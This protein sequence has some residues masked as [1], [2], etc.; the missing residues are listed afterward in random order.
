MNIQE[1]VQHAKETEPRLAKLNSARGDILLREVFKQIVSEIRQKSQ[2]I[3]KVPGLGQFITKKALRMK[4]GVKRGAKAVVFKAS[5]GAPSAKGNEPMV[6][7]DDSLGYR[8]WIKKNEPKDEELRGQRKMEF[9]KAPKIS[10]ITPVFKTPTKMLVDMIESV[11]T[12]TYSRWE[13]CIVDGCSGGGRVRKILEKYS[14][15]DARIKVKFLDKNMGISGNSNEAISL[16]TGEFVSFLDHDDVLSPDALFE[17]VQAINQHPRVDLL[18]SD[19]DHISKDGKTRFDPFFK[20]DFAP[21]TLR[22]YNYIC[23][24][25]VLKRELGRS[26]GWFRS[27]FDG[28]QDYDLILRAAEKAKKVIHISKILYHWRGHANSTA[29]TE[30]SKPYAY[31]AGEGCL[32]DHLKRM[33]LR[34]TVQAQEAPSGYKINYILSKEQLVSIIIPNRDNADLLDRCVGSILERTTYKN[35]E[36]L[37]LE[38]RSVEEKTFKLYKKLGKHKNVRIIPGDYVFNYSSLNNFAVKKVRGEVVLFLNNDTE[39]ISPDWIENM[40]QYAIRPDVGAVGAKLYY[41]NGTVQHAGII[42]GLGGIAGHSHKYFSRNHKGNYGRLKVV[43]NLS[44]VTGACLM[45]RKSVFEEIRGFDRRLPLSF[46][47]VDLCLK[48]RQ[49]GYLIVWTPYAELYHHESKS[50]G[51]DNTPPKILRSNREAAF[52]KYKWARILWEG[53]PYYNCNLTLAAENFG[54]KVS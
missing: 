6:L 31:K 34:G 27:G 48:I 15:E 53:D 54:I 13:L 18:Y 32:G 16:S 17:V 29:G 8:Y 37:I 22:S 30:N 14:R 9:K 44:A 20:P 49:K 51:L 43:Q 11:I 52:M 26:L 40:L 7:R 1:R 28:A 23:H 45:M 21:D 39:V 50:R 35:I 46:N 42:V 33:G 25:L 36:I 19:E 10:I 12:Q 3:V 41:P 4:G 2:G 24:F 38:N 47:D 5:L